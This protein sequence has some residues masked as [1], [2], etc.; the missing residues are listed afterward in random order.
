LK[1]SAVLPTTT[2]PSSWL[3]HPDKH[4]LHAYNVIITICCE[5]IPVY[6]QI[7]H[8]RIHNADAMSSIYQLRGVATLSTYESRAVLHTSRTLHVLMANKGSFDVLSEL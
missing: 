1:T 2:H 8:G 5:T 6:L 4:T 3:E 7:L